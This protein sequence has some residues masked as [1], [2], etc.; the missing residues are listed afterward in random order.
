MSSDLGYNLARWANFF[1]AEVGASAAL[2]G[3]L[4]VAISINLT[5]IVANPLLASRSAKALATL[6]G[7]LL[8]CTLCLVPELSLRGLGWALTILGAVVWLMITFWQTKAS[9][10]NPYTTFVHK[11]LHSILAQASAL[12]LVIC[13]VSLLLMRGG[14]LYWLVATTVFSFVAAMLDAWVLLVEIQR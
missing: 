11:L 8:A 5:K 3:L 9:R 13:G 7:V 1:S 2:T 14:G 10:R 6:T 4:F 12:P